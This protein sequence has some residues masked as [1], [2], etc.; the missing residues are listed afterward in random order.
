MNDRSSRCHPGSDDSS[1][2]SDASVGVEGSAALDPRW[3][4]A[5]ICLHQAGYHDLGEFIDAQREIAEMLLATLVHVE[6][7]C[8]AM[9]DEG[10]MADGS[11]GFITAAIAKAEGRS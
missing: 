3:G 10:L 4:Q 7:S 9:A 6:G 1:L 8:E 5:A 11:W 2:R